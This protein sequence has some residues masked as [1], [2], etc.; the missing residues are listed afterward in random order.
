VDT[1]ALRALTDVAMTRAAKKSALDKR[2][3]VVFLRDVAVD[4]RMLFP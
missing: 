4:H 2:Q 3:R 1:I